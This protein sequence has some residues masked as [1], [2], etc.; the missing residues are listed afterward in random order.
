MEEEKGGEGTFAL[1]SSILLSF[2][3][4]YSVSFCSALFPSALL[5]FL[6]LCSALFSSALPC[7]LLLSSPPLSYPLLFS[8]LLFSPLLFSP[9][10]FSPLLFS[11][12]LSSPLLSSPLLSSPL[13]FPPL[14]SSPLLSSLSSQLS[15]CYHDSFMTASRELLGAECRFGYAGRS[16]ESSPA[17]GYG[18][19]HAREQDAI[20]KQSFASDGP[21][22]GH[23]LE[24]SE[25][26]KVRK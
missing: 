16:T 12:L 20:L 18:A 4:L 8:P 25:F 21:V 11:P 24:S 26:A 5:C 19:V 15:S 9:L 10:L 13:L 7:F 17:S 2:L 3:L 6:L 1:F 14:R 23:G 22:W